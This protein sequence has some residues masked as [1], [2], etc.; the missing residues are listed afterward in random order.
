MRNIWSHDSLFYSIIDD[1]D[2]EM[3]P[4]D[5]VNELS[6][7]RAYVAQLIEFEEFKAKM[8]TAVANYMRS[9]GCSCCRDTE[10]HE[11][12]AAI[13]AGL[14]DVPAHDD[15]SGFDFCQFRND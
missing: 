10:A 11:K 8:R 6:K 4:E 14:L 9:E 12:H 5:V 15:N 1:D 3:A 13:L 7:L 2:N